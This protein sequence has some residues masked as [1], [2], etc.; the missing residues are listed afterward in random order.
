VLVF[1][2]VLLLV[3]LNVVEV[4]VGGDGDA[5]DQQ[6]HLGEAQLGILVEVQVLHDFING[7][8]AFHMLQRKGQVC[9]LLLNQE[10]ELTLGQGV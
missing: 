4:F 1:V 9:K 5:G 8:L 10:L 3:V 7:G 6:D 2:L